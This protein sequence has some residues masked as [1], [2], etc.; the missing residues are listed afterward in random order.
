MEFQCWVN[1]ILLGEH[2][3]KFVD[4]VKG[5]ELRKEE[6]AESAPNSHRYYTLCL[7][8]NSGRKPITRKSTYI[9]DWKYIASR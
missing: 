6:L 3:S 1:E 7:A 4:D 8:P 5:I 9:N 2:M